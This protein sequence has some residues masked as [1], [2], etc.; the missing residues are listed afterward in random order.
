MGLRFRC[1]Y[2]R[3]FP[4]LSYSLCCTT[5]PRSGH[6][7]DELGMLMGGE[8]ILPHRVSSP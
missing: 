6:F 8:H 4:A 5:F 7:E 3:I 2:Q 1:T